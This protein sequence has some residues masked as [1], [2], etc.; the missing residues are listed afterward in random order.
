M[1]PVSYLDLLLSGDSEIGKT[2]E[3]IF[4]KMDSKHRRILYFSLKKIE[5]KSTWDPWQNIESYY[6]CLILL[7]CLNSCY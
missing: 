3:K 6:V 1:I 7:I 5:K 4:R 2:T